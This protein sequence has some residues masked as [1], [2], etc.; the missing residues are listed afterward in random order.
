MRML[1]KFEN[2]RRQLDGFRPCPDDA[3]KSHMPLK[4][5]TVHNKK[6]SHTIKNDGCLKNQKPTQLASTTE[7]K[8]VE[9]VKALVARLSDGKPT[10]EHG[11][12]AVAARRH[13]WLRQHFFKP[14]VDHVDL[15]RP[16]YAARSS[17]QT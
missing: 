15:W 13:S 3:E 17:A 14:D 7:F 11:A 5:E 16:V 12:D 4:A 8:T 9:L 6:H 2:E 1:R 10:S